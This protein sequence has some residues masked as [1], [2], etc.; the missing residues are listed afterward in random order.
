M[1]SYSS[2]LPLERS[3]SVGDN[4]AGIPSFFIDPEGAARRVHTK[5]FW[6]GPLVIISIAGI[7]VGSLIIPIVQHVM[8]VA[9][10]PPGATPE[11]FQ[12]GVAISL[13]IQKILFT[14]LGPVLA[15]AVLAI[16]AGLLAAISSVMGVK[17]TFRQLFNLVSGCALIGMLEQ[18]AVIVILKAKGDISS[19][20]EL[21]PPMGID[22]FLS[23]GTNKF[24]LAFLGYFSI[25]QIWWIV[26]LVLIFAVAFRVTKGKALSVV[27]PMVLLGLAWRLAM[28][29][30]QR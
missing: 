7:I 23:E 29:A 5:W 4:L 25:F 1:A 24:L 26:M 19:V 11:Q 8:E 13:M 6:I 9:P 3:E 2:E 16:E 30:F 14:Y 22:I 17:T 27:A 18:I 21:R 12:K 20:A 10:L 28:T 15:A